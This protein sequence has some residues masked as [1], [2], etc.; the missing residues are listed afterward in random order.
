[1]PA[2]IA[3]FNEKG[4]DATKLKKND[5]VALLLSCYCVHTVAALKKEKKL[6]STRTAAGGTLAAS[7]LAV[8]TMASACSVAAGTS[9]DKL[10]ASTATAATATKETT[11]LD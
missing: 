1:V 10:A 6:F 11:Y 4:R 2:A 5:T 9:A 7:A 3:K 8:A